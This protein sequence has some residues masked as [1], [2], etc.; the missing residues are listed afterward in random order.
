M[1]NYPSL[2]MLFHLLLMY[3]QNQQQ[4]LI[5][6]EIPNHFMIMFINIIFLIFI[7]LAVVLITL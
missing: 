4:H 3:L 6:M 1:F 5:L 7:N 2:L